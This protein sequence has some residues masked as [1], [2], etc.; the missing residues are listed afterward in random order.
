MCLSPLSLTSPLLHFC[1]Y[2]TVPRE[3]LKKPMKSH[4]A[5]TC[6]RTHAHTPENEMFVFSTVNKQTKKKHPNVV[7]LIILHNKIFSTCKKCLCW[8]KI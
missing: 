7:N 5:S 4:I 2:Q 8:Y 3:D 6:T 1:I